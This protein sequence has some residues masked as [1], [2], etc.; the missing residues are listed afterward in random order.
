MTYSDV[1][2]GECPGWKAAVSVNARPLRL[3]DIRRL[4][5]RLAAERAEVEMRFSPDWWNKGFTLHAGDI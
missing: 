4:M 2:R 3:L 5:W 1:R